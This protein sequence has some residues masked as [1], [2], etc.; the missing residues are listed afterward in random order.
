MPSLALPP[1]QRRKYLLQNAIDVVVDVDV[2]HADN[3]VSERCYR[4]RAL[5][6]VGNLALRT[7]CAT[8]HLDN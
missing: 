6:I 3:F 4:L 1:L 7:V 2:V 8:V 5:A